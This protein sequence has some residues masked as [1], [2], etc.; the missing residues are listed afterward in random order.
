MVKKFLGKFSKNH[1]ISENAV[2]FTKG[3]FLSKMQTGIFGSMEST[4]SLVCQNFNLSLL[5]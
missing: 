1:E 2:S 5:L 4:P 3:N